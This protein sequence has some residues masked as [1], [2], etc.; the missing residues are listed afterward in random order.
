MAI[1]L[2][3]GSMYYKL[4]KINHMTSN[5]VGENKE[6][7]PQDLSENPCLAFSTSIQAATRMMGR[8]KCISVS[9]MAY[10]N[11]FKISSPPSFSSSWVKPF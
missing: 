11:L 2:M 10:L 6:S 1:K 4:F 7:W 3:G 5:V 9:T 8:Q